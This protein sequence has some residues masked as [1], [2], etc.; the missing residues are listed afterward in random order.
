[1]TVLLIEDK[2]GEGLHTLQTVLSHP[3]QIP[4]IMMTGQT[5]EETALQAVQ[6]GAQRYS[7]IPGKL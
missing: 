3:P 7:S 4:V 5:D 1:M 2:P 6:S